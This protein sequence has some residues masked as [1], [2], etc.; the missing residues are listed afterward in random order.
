[1]LDRLGSVFSEN[2]TGERELY[3]LGEKKLGAAA[4]D[5][6]LTARAETNTRS[7]LQAL[8]GSLG[9]EH[10]TIRYQTPTGT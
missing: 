6:K 9:F 5:S 2:P 8:F 4:A 10:I 1:M 3:Q 7:M